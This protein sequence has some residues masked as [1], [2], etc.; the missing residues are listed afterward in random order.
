MIATKALIGIYDGKREGDK[1]LPDGDHAIWSH[2]I[3]NAFLRT[4][5]TQTCL[6]KGTKLAVETPFSVLDKQNMDFESVLNVLGVAFDLR[7]KVFFHT[8]HTVQS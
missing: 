4:V 7:P 5:I 6:S 8:K 2:C 3:S 1:D